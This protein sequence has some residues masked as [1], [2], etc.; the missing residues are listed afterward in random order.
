MAV[1]VNSVAVPTSM[2]NRGRYLFTPP[3]VVAT[4]GLGDAVTAGASSIE[5]TWPVVTAT[6]FA[7]WWT[8]L[9]AGAGSAR[10]GNNRFRDVTGTET[11]YSV[12]VVERPT[13]EHFT[14]DSYRNFTVR[15]TQ[16]A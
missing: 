7:Y 12:C 6:E 2:V 4:N 9:G 5:W 10:H 11:A 13:W 3:P 16:I 1:Q 15:I 14:G 8:T